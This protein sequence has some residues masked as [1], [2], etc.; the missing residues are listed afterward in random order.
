MDLLDRAIQR[1]QEVLDVLDV[2]VL[3]GLVKRLRGFI[4]RQSGVGNREMTV[5]ILY[6]KARHAL[7]EPLGVCAAQK[8]FSAALQLL[9]DE[10]RFE[11]VNRAGV[12]TLLLPVA[13]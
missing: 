5:S 12:P 10:G 8:H 1:R 13:L 4:G 6:A 9:E 3:D 7:D 2:D 11:L